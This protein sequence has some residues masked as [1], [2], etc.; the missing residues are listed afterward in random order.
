[1]IFGLLT[2]LAKTSAQGLLAICNLPDSVVKPL[3][4]KDT[5]EC[6]SRPTSLFL[7]GLSKS[8]LIEEYASGITLFRHQ[9][10]LVNN[11]LKRPFAVISAR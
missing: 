2:S 5:F 7:D 8:D 3:P 11:P 6:G 10:R 9:K 4:H 1:M